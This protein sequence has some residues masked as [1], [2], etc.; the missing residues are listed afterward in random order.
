MLPKFK[1]I[2]VTVITIAAMKQ[3]LLSLMKTLTEN[4]NTLPGIAFEQ[5]QTESKIIMLMLVQRSIYTVR[6]NN[7]RMAQWAARMWRLANHRRGTV[8]V[9]LSF[10]RMTF[11]AHV[12]II[13]IMLKMFSTLVCFLIHDSLLLSLHFMPSIMLSIPFG[14][15]EVF[16]PGLLLESRFRIHMLDLTKRTNYMP[17]SSVWDYFS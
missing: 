14:H 4:V 5:H 15:F 3:Q 17:F 2:I 6:M 11:P 12:Q 16:V 7:F 13:F 8:T 1:R 9:L 10:R